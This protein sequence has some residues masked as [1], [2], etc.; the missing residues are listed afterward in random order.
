MNEA[1]Q[2]SWWQRNWKWFVPTLVVSFFALVGALVGAGVFLVF[3]MVK[4]SEVYQEALEAAQIH[5]VVQQRLGQPIE[6]GWLVMGS[7][8]TSGGS[9]DAD[10]TIP[11]S[12]PDGEAHVYAVATRFAGQWT[13]QRL[14][15]VFDDSGKRIDL[16]E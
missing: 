15:V 12:G 6:P 10:L 4:S 2:A 1:V 5:P 11:I 14:D 16:L 9:G 8:S 3:G 13:F 7:I